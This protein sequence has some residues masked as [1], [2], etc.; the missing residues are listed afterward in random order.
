MVEPLESVRLLN[1]QKR[2]RSSHWAVIMYSLHH[3]VNHHPLFAHVPGGSN[4]GAATPNRSGLIPKLRFCTKPP[5][6]MVMVTT[7][8]PIKRSSTRKYHD[9]LLCNAFLRLQHDISVGSR[10]SIL[11]LALAGSNVVDS[12]FKVRATLAF[13]VLA[14]HDFIKKSSLTQVTQTTQVLQNNRQTNMGLDTK[15]FIFTLNL[16]I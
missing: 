3:L 12:T 16:H 13:R 14:S 4:L 7:E 10:R 5:Q 1:G 6:V 9:E 2:I 8:H 11:F 15:I